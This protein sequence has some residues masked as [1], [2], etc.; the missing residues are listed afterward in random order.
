MADFTKAP[1]LFDG[2]FMFLFFKK[3]TEVFQLPFSL[4]VQAVKLH[5]PDGTLQCE[6]VYQAN[7]WVQLLQL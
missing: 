3:V 7:L 2:A 4:I 5:I 6:Q 1:L